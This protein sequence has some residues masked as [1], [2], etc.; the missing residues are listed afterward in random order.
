MIEYKK[1]KGKK[2]F[3]VDKNDNVTLWVEGGM[4]ING[5]WE[6][7]FDMDR[8]EFFVPYAEEERHQFKA[9]FTA[10]DIEKKY[11]HMQYNEAIYEAQRHYDKNKE[12]ILNAKSPSETIVRKGRYTALVTHG[13]DR[14]EIQIDVFRAE[15]IENKIDEKHS[16]KKEI[17]ALDKEKIYSVDSEVF[18][19]N[20][21][22]EIPALAEKMIDRVSEMDRVKKINIFDV[23]EE[24][25]YDRKEF[26][27][28]DGTD[29]KPVYMK[30]KLMEDVVIA[31]KYK[32][33]FPDDSFVV[34]DTRIDIVGVD[35]FGKNVE[36]ESGGDIDIYGVDLTGG[37]V[38]IHGDGEVTIHANTLNMDCRIT[39]NCNVSLEVKNFGENAKVVLEN[40]GKVSL[41]KL[42]NDSDEAISKEASVTFR[43]KGDVEVWFCEKFPD[44]FNFENEGLVD[45]DED[46]LDEE[47][48]IHIANLENSVTY[49]DRTHFGLSGQPL[50]Q[51]EIDKILP[52]AQTIPAA[53]MGGDDNLE[54]NEV[55]AAQKM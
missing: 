44:R 31:G 34:Y 25:A 35:R 19:G 24:R 13:N 54:A 27:T 46:R 3:V 49:K 2:M 47:S 40:T 48:K 38:T 1:A 9:V 14:G 42:T 7:D 21:Q 4:V 45:F 28:P 39:G 41:T 43:N 36:I 15:D 26:S 29:G 53:N 37:P 22:E 8:K 23:L 16:L 20:I 30:D 17:E 10:P 51:D 55:I 18:L 5:N 11:S 12:E 6:I 33:E 32:F 50:S 52:K